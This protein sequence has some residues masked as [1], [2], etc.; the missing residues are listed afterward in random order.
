[1]IQPYEILRFCVGYLK[2]D[3][4]IYIEDCCENIGQIRSGD[5]SVNTNISNEDTV[6]F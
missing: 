3:I 2:R 6:A 1:M 5:V 4:I